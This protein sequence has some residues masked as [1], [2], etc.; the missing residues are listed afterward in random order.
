MPTVS[1]AALRS[2]IK[3]SLT[4]NQM[5]E[6]YGDFSHSK[7]ATDIN[8]TLDV[9]FSTTA[10][11]SIKR[12]IVSSD[13][14]AGVLFYKTGVFTVISNVSQAIDSSGNAILTCH[15]GNELSTIIPTEINADELL[16][17]SFVLL[18]KETPSTEP[19]LDNLM[20]T[21]PASDTVTSAEGIEKSLFEDA[22]FTSGSSRSQRHAR[23]KDASL[24]PFT[25]RPQ[26]QEYRTNGRRWCTSSMRRTRRY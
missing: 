13:D 26:C 21:T 18:M 19:N 12:V 14:T 6:A 24:Y 3:T 4:R 16:G 9:W 25:L 1:P 8:H 15:L 23:R 10:S 17:E 2:L 11:S 22:T 20:C 7:P 5:D